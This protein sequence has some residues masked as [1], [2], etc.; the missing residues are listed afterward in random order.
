MSTKILGI[1]LLLLLF[2]KNTM[3]SQQVIDSLFTKDIQEPTYNSE[4][5]PIIYLDEGHNNGS[6][7][8]TSFKPTSNILVKDGYIVK[9]NREQISNEIL[10]RAD[11]LVVIDA[12]ASENIDNWKLPTPSAFTDDEILSIHEWVEKGGSLLLVADHMPFAG[13]SKKLGKAFGVNFI[14]GFA[15]DTIGWDLTRFSRGENSLRQHPI[16]EGRNFDEQVNEISTY[17][18]QCLAISEIGLNPIMVFSNENIVSYNPKEAWKFN[19]ETKTIPSKG[20]YQGVAGEYGKGRI[21]VL[22]DSSIIL[23]HLIGKNKRTIGIN[24]VETKNNYQFMLNI[25]HWLSQ[26]Y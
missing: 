9:S 5:S 13:A 20:Y 14:N 4:N 22:G 15:I 24:S 19:N 7:L 6:Q 12:L 25:F 17:F 21:V 1:F 3:L 11:I 8:N 10:N 26:L 16:I 18:G 2:N 23:A